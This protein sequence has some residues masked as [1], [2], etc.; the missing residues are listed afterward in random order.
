VVG[1]KDIDSNVVA[2]KLIRHHGLVIPMSADVCKG[3]ILLFDEK[4]TWP[5]LSMP[6]ELQ[7]NA[8]LSSNEH[9]GCIERSQH[10]KYKDVI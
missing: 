6:P 2:T 7:L 8:S 9:H 10:E 4:I 3:K 5:R 1:I